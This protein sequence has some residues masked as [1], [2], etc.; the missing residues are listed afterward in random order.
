MAQKSFRHQLVFAAFT[1]FALAI[2]GLGSGSANAQVAQ[3]TAAVGTAAVP[4]S[5]TVASPSLTLLWQ[6]GVAHNDAVSGAFMITVDAQGNCYVGI[7]NFTVKEFDPAGNVVGTFGPAS[8][9]SSQ[10]TGNITGLAVDTQGN[11]YVADWTTSHIDK[12]DPKGKFLMQWAT[13]PPSG[14]GGIALDSKGNLY[15]VYHGNHPYL[16]QKYDTRGKLLSQWGKE[17]YVAGQFNP[18]SGQTIAIDSHD[19]LYVA[20]A[21]NSRIVKFDSD[22]NLLAQFGSDSINGP[23]SISSIYPL[24]VAVDGQGDIYVNDE[25][26]LQK[27]DPTGKLVAQWSTAEQPGSDLDRAGDIAL[28]GQGNMYVIANGDVYSPFIKRT[29]NIPVLKKFRLP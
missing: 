3:S 10:V 11:L 13:E 7:D 12:F 26:S 5:P 25:V 4:A 1:G 29:A 6:T 16:V 28:D 2:V 27:F 14:P 24:A 8:M 21:V 18:D 19:N 9:G 17:G 23:A 20:D 15:L 22:G